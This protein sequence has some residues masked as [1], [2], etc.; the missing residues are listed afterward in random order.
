MKRKTFARF[1]TLM[2]I[3]L[4]ITGCATS[5]YYYKYQG[6]AGGFSDIKIQDDI[7]KVSY[8]ENSFVSVETAEDFALLRA[9]EVTLTNGYK[10]FIIL[11]QKSDPHTTS[12]TIPLSSMTVGSGVLAP[13]S[14]TGYASTFNYG[15]GTVTQSRP[16]TSNLIQ[17]YKDKPLDASLL[18]YDAKQVQDSLKAKHSIH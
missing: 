14:V 1:A 3:S 8:S 11:D 6:A 9:A 5:A 7:Y 15:G 4:V 2:A 17:C 16:S 10:Y 12:S 18:I 13:G